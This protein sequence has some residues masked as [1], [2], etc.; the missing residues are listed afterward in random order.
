[1]RVASPTPPGT[2]LPSRAD[3]VHSS[4][5]FES[6]LPF[7]CGIHPNRLPCVR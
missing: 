4:A 2:A 5:H 3:R 7:Y 1:L 6:A